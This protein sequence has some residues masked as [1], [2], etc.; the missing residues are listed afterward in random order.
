MRMCHHLSNIPILRT[1]TTQRAYRL[2]HFLPEEIDLLTDVDSSLAKV[3]D[4]SFRYSGA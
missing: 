1:W 4:N 2:V 3:D